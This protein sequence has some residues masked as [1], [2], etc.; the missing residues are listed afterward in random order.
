MVHRPAHVDL[1]CEPLFSDSLSSVAVGAPEAA[2]YPARV[3]SLNDVEL[4]ALVAE[5]VVDCYDEHEQLS[6]LF[7]MLEVEDNLAVPFGTEVLGV[8]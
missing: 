1:A 5:A 3:S 6:G 2:F 7:T 4:A 8:R